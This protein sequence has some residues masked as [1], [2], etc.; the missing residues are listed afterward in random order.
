MKYKFFNIDKIESSEDLKKQYRRLAFELHPDRGGEPEQFKAMGNEYEALFK[1]YGSI[2]K[3][4]DGETYPKEKNESSNKFKNIIDSIIRYNVNIDVVGSWIWV[5]GSET[6]SI[7]E[8]LKSMGFN[9][10][11]GKKK[12]YYNGNSYTKKTRK[13]LSYEEIKYYYGAETVKEKTELKEISTS[14]ETRFK[15][16]GFCPFFYLSFKPIVND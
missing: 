16:K 2:F 10:A 14:H 12:W 11:K 4:K 8:V 6:Y 1:T 3:T 13:Y 15:K 5:Y 7:K 9:W